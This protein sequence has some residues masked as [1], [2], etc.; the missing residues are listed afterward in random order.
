M[1][2]RIG[3]DWDGMGWVGIRGIVS[4]WDGMEY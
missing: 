2:F 4:N 3:M 1:L